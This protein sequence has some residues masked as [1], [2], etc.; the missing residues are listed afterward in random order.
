MTVGGALSG[1]GTLD[2]VATR[3]QHALDAGRERAATV[4]RLAV[5]RY[6]GILV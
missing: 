1:R 5:K 3:L 6:G 4:A 2:S